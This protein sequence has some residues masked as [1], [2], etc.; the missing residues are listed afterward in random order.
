MSDRDLYATLGVSPKATTAAIQRARDRRLTRYQRMRES[1]VPRRQIEAEEAELEVIQAAQVLLDPER[2]RE[3]DR[4]RGTDGE[5]AA[6]SALRLRATMPVA[7]GILLLVA[8]A[9]A[10]ISFAHLLPAP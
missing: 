6:A 10:V 1:A 9:E 3:Y 2:R 5:A 4:Q 8:G 7:V